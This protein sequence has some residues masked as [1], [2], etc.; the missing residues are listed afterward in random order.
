MVML[1]S[2]KKESNSVIICI[3]VNAPATFGAGNLTPHTSQGELC[4]IF[5]YPP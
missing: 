1:I 4:L 5:D 2:K 3:L